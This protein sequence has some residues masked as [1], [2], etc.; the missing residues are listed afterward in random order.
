MRHLVVFLI[1][2]SLATPVYADPPKGKTP[3]AATP[4]TDGPPQLDNRMKSN[5][6][7]VA[8]WNS[9]GSK[10]QRGIQLR[11]QM[12]RAMDAREKDKKPAVDAA[13]VAEMKKAAEDVK[14]AGVKQ[15][16]QTAPI[17][18]V[19]GGNAEAK[20]PPAGDQQPQTKI[21]REN[22]NRT[23][24]KE[25]HKDSQTEGGLVDQDCPECGGVQNTD[26]LS[27]EQRDTAEQLAEPPPPRRRVVEEDEDVVERRPF[28]WR[29][30]LIGGAVGLG[31]GF[32]L[33]HFLNKNNNNNR[34]YQ[35][36]GG[37]GPGGQGYPWWQN[38]GGFRQLPGV[39]RAPGMMP[40]M[41]GI[42]GFGGGGGVPPWAIGGG[43]PG[44]GLGYGGG[45][46]AGGGFGYGGGFGTGAAP[47]ALPYPGPAVGSYNGF[48]NVY[49]MPTGVNSALYG[50]SGIPSIVQGR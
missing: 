25:N 33:S 38:P 24:G 14:K 32:L 1:C 39:Y 2:A 34:C 11:N 18:I 44:Y 19:P 30:G 29:S 22:D 17:P 41:P 6:E 3:P 28:D 50:N 47:I 48:S 7:L 23:S 16:S 37:W 43:M 20:A 15:D 13:L 9:Y 8:V 5:P 27:K 21:V 35:N 26:P 40:G 49:N 42:G 45:Y 36:G 31:A 4:S 12:R 46:G 10:D